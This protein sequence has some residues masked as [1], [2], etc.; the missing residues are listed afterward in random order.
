M[1]EEK[2]R[3]FLN[4]QNLKALQPAFNILTQSHE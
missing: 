1:D 2:R 3:D 4:P